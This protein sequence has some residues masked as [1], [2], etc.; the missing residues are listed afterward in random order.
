VEAAA[1]PASYDV[2]WFAF[3]NATGAVTPIGQPVSTAGEPVNAPSGLPAAPGSFVRVDITAASPSHPSW[4]VP[5]HAYFQRTGG[6]WRLVGLER[7][8]EPA[9]R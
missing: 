5:V 4:S 6:G 8:P 7:L 1:P 9:R 2:R 3:D